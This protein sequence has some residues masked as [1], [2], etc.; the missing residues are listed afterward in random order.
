MRYAFDL[1]GRRH[2]VQLEEHADGPKYTIEGTTFEPKVEKL[3]KGH[4][5][6][7]IG[8]ETFEFNLEGGTIHEGNEM[9]DVQVNRAKPELIR[10]GGKGRKADGRIKPPM[11][12]KVVEV[13]VEVGAEISEG[14]P[15]LV[16]EAMKMQND[17]KSPVT[18]TV[19]TVHVSAGQ[20]VEAATVL[21]EIEVPDE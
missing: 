2:F 6:V 19:K 3:G 13:H 12:G 16:L 20:N 10:A 18:G 8:D 7:T 11:P 1:A 21:I 4:Y 5:K 14:D 17:L 15:L 9:L